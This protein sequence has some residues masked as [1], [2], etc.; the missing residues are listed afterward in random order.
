MDFKSACTPKIQCNA[1]P[2]KVIHIMVNRFLFFCSLA[3]HNFLVIHQAIQSAK[4]VEPNKA[5]GNKIGISVEH[6]CFDLC[7]AS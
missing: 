6:Y 4:N 7:L 2:S 3:L 1:I 5:L